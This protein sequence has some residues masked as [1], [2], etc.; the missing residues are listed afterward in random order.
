MRRLSLILL[1]LCSI[2]AFGQDFGRVDSLRSVADSRHGDERAGTLIELAEAFRVFS[3]DESV[4]CAQEAYNM[5]KASGNAALQAEAL[6]QMGEAYIADYS[7]DLAKDCFTEAFAI[8]RKMGKAAD[9]SFMADNAGYVAMVMG[10]TLEAEYYL[11]YSYDICD[12]LQLYYSAAVSLNE[13]GA[14][15]YNMGDLDRSMDCFYRARLYFEKDGD[16]LSM[17]ECENNM[18]VPLIDAGDYVQARQKLEGIIPYLER[19]GDKTTLANAF[20]NLGIIYETHYKKYDSALL[21]AD[22]ALAIRLVE[23]DSM[24]ICQSWNEMGN[25][26]ILS[27][28]YDEATSL[29]KKA[30]ATSKS[31]GYHDGQTEALVRLGE[32]SYLKGDIRQSKEYFGKAREMTMKLKNDWKYRNIINKGL[33]LDH[34]ASGDKKSLQRELENLINDYD[35]IGRQYQ[36]MV[37]LQNR[38]RYNLSDYE[39]RIATLENTVE[40]AEKQRLKTIYILVSVVFIEALVC[41]V[42]VLVRRR[43]K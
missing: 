2:L 16:S 21:F 37:L 4:A 6:Y 13:L 23:A 33:V 18:A 42:M 39:Q 1:L 11:T 9:A 12:S 5:A 22:K 20:H 24:A 17:A 30:L 31:I 32:A 15:Y 34:A 35:L 36:H 43:K 38:E 7:F 3:V 25:I 19:V 10:M 29:L 8:Y 28:K 41:V 14:L 26:N 27:G 40:R